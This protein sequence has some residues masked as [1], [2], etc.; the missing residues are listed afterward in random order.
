ML[1]YRFCFGDRLTNIF[2]IACF[3]TTQIAELLGQK[4]DSDD[5]RTALV[6]ATGAAV[7]LAHPVAILI[8]LSP[9]LSLPIFQQKRTLYVIEALCK[10]DIIAICE[11]IRPLQP[12]IEAF[13]GAQQLNARQQAA[14]VCDILPSSRPFYRRRG[15]ASC[16]S[17][18]PPFPQTDPAMPAAKC[19]GPCWTCL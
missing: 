6:R 11:C 3:L 10:S 18:P 9:S 17:T 1:C 7:F 15:K 8:F 13:S 2:S 4:L 19:S 5:N 14:K 12:K 16:S